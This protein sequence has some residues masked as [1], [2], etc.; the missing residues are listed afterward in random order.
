MF[1]VRS[2]LSIVV[3][4]ILWNIWTLCALSCSA[5]VE[6]RAPCRMHVFVSTLSG[7]CNRGMRTELERKDREKK[8]ERDTHTHTQTEPDRNKD[9]KKINIFSHHDKMP[10]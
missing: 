5:S 3:Q 6:P 9:E 2:S 1:P 8:R 10:L 4:P 7:A